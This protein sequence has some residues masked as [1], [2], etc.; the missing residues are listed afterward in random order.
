MKKYVLIALTAALMLLC[1]L[2]QAQ[3]IPEAI[4]QNHIYEGFEVVDTL[5]V[6]DSGWGFATF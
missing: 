6:K 4:V 5:E 2:A 3:T 1:L